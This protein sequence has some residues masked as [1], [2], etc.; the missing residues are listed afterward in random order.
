MKPNHYHYWQS[1]GIQSEN[2][3]HAHARRVGRRSTS[4]CSKVCSSEA[5]MKST[6]KKNFNAQHCITLQPRN[7]TRALFLLHSSWHIMA[8]Y[9]PPC[10]L[11]TSRWRMLRWFC[12]GS[13]GRSYHLSTGLPPD[14]QSWVFSWRPRSNNLGRLGLLE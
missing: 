8:T 13:P 10:A 1:S 6:R 7:F 5:N 11:L 9:G 2:K 14:L 12:H 4:Q 3:D